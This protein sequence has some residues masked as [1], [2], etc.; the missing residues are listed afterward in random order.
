M[1]TVSSNMGVITLSKKDMAPF[2]QVPF[3]V[4]YLVLSMDFMYCGNLSLC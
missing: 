1:V 2:G 3:A 4:K